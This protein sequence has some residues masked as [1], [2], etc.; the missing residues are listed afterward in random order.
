[1]I[2]PNL[3]ITKSNK[4]SSSF[5]ELNSL[6]NL[7]INNNNLNTKYPVPLEPISNTNSS[8]SLINT[9]S[10]LEDSYVP[11]NLQYNSY[12]NLKTKGE[13]ILKTRKI[14]TVSINNPNANFMNIIDG[15]STNLS[16]VNS[17]NQKQRKRKHYIQKR[18]RLAPLPKSYH[19]LLL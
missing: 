8:H 11:E 10:Y 17:L 12:N 7:N 1:M 2:K 5:N 18:P 4:N 19:N 6:D 13:D 14:C 16:S 3:I 15:H 9:S